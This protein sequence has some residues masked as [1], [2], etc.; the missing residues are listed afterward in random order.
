MAYTKV[1]TEQLW[2]LACGLTSILLDP[3][4][5]VQLAHRA[6]EVSFQLSIEPERSPANSVYCNAPIGALS[7]LVVANQLPT[8]SGI[9]D[10]HQHWWR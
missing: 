7:C 10:I 1:S 6:R 4:G 9:S 5:L 2:V 8:F 3:A